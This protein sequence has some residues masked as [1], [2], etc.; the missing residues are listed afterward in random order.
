MTLMYGLGLT[1]IGL[2]TQLKEKVLIAVPFCMLGLGL[3]AT[4]MDNVL[5]N[6]Y[7]LGGKL[8]RKVFTTANLCESLTFVLPP[9]PPLRNERC[10]L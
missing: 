5:F 1:P 9:P 2:V 10:Y 7:N 8:K 3:Q 6:E 4:L